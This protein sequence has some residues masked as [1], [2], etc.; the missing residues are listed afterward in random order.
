[1]KLPED[2]TRLAASQ[3]DGN[4]AWRSRTGDILELADGPPEHISIEKDQGV[5]GLVLCR[6]TDLAVDC[7]VVEEG[8]H[9]R[10]AQTVG[11]R[12]AVKD[13]ES[14]NPAGIRL[15]GTGTEMTTPGYL[16]DEK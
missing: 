13:R 5:E 1:V 14:L 8:L 16:V 11:R 4:A 6:S 15:L 3:N 10:F 12:T 9:L 2:G 7:E